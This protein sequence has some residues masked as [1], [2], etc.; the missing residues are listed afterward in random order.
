MNKE[1][2]KKYNKE[3]EYDNKPLGKIIRNNDESG[4]ILT[5]SIFHK[6]SDGMIYEF[7]RNTRRELKC[8]EVKQ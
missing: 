7:E 1:E 6:C 4:Y 2:I 8:F 5:Y 3:Q